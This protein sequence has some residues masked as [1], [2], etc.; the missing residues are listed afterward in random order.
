M[1]IKKMICKILAGYL[2]LC[3]A[4]VNAGQIEIG[5]ISQPTGDLARIPLSQPMER[6]SS[7][8]VEEIN[9]R[10]AEYDPGEG[11]LLHNNA[12]HYFYYENLDPVAKEIYDVLYGV[13]EDPVSEGNIGIMMTD[14]DPESM[15]YY[16]LFNKAFR[17]LTYD[18][19]ELFWLY[20]GE[21]AGIGYGSEAILQNGFYLVY[22]QMS[23][24][25][26]NFEAQMTDFNRAADEFL[27]SI[28]TSGSEYNTVLQIHDKLL[29]LVNYNDPV[30]DGITPTR[31]GLDL[32]HTAYGVLVRDSAGIPNYAVCDGYSLA[33]E[34]LLQQCGIN[35]I[36][37]GGYGGATEATAGGHAWNEVQ[38]D[39]EWYEVDVTWDDHGSVI[40]DISPAM[41][42][43]DLWME[44]LEDSDYRNKIDHY[45]FLISTDNLRNYIADTKYMFTSRQGYQYSLV[46]NSVHI[47]FNE[48]ERELW[49][50]DP[51]CEL[52]GIAPVGILNY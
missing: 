22:F 50:I 24:P 9:M 18:H 48:A 45:M 19:P 16:Y 3:A 15:E 35:A 12:S 39:N 10:M 6:L 5:K 13:C 11:K 46:N 7:Q 17:A 30:A 41:E 52:F 32:A 38:I 8:D 40:D 49:G 26:R 47:R 31:N 23:K 4:S 1:R 44:A 34:Y 29:D 27:R 28:D 25:F 43:Y 37:M 51:D 2:I 36:F 20:S 42:D 14:M 33:F 21:E